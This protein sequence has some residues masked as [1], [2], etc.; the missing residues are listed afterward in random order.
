MVRPPPLSSLRHTKLCVCGVCSYFL[1]RLPTRLPPES[2]WN[3]HLDAGRTKKVK[4]AS[5]ERPDATVAAAAFTEAGE[6]RRQAQ[7][8]SGDGKGYRKGGDEV[9]KKRPFQKGSNSR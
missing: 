8:L 6:A 5:A 1:N 2:E 3:A 9:A 7:S 4:V